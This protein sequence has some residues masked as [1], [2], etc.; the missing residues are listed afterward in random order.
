MAFHEIGRGRKAMVK[1]RTIMNVPLPINKDNFDNI[2]DNKLYDAYI[3]VELLKVW[4]E[5]HL[6]L[7]K[8]LTEAVKMMI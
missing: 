1:F 5:L 6:K 7:G 4:K 2:N 8:L 3:W